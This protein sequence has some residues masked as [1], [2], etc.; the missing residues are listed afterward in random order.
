MRRDRPL[1]RSVVTILTLSITLLACQPGA[2]A[3]TVQLATTLPSLA[4]QRLDAPGV[5]EIVL[6]TP[7]EGVGQRPL[8]EWQPVDGT[9]RYALVVYNAKGKA[10]WAWEGKETSV[11]LGGGQTRPPDESVGPVLQEGMSWSVMAFG[12]DERLIATSN[13]SPIS[14]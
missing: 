9:I 2:Q 4:R 11:Y 8:F 13:V 6:T 10:Y 14:P 12:A 1:N 7:S 5:A 3:T